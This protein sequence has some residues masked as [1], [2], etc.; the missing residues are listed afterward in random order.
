LANTT[1]PSYWMYKRRI[2]MA[3]ETIIIWFRI[4]ITYMKSLPNYLLNCCNLYLRD[5]IFVHNLQVQPTSGNKYILKRVEVLILH[6]FNYQLPH[7]H[8]KSY[9]ASQIICLRSILMWEL[10]TSMWSCEERINWT[11]CTAWY[12]Y[13]QLTETVTSLYL[14]KHHTTKTMWEAEA[15]FHTFSNLCFRWRQVVSFMPSSHY[16]CTQRIC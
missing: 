10:L 15:W 1:R 12:R 8:S 13:A 7:S 5:A 2:L 14:I 9:S 11:I 4:I 16:V 6:S 3:P